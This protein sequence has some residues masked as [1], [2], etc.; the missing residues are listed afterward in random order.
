VIAKH[1]RL[2]AMILL[3]ILAIY[4][5]TGASVAVAFIAF[6]LRRV[7]PHIS[8]TAG[9]RLLVLPGAVALWPLVVSRWLESR[10]ANDTPASFLAP[11]AVGCPHVIRGVGVCQ[12]TSAASTRPC[13][14]TSHN[15]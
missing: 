10:A 12:R 1:Q 4:A 9:A 11:R 8:M 3:D 2:E 13:R 7:L 5:M 15:Q 6:G 14:N